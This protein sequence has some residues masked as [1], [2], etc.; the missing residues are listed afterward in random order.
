MEI[1]TPRVGR[2]LMLTLEEGTTAGMAAVEAATLGTRTAPEVVA[3]VEAV[4]VN[5]A[6]LM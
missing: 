2:E 1:R 3:L 6:T 5:L 4:D